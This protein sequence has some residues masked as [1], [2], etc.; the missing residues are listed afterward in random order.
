MSEKLQW[1]NKLSTA[2]ELAKDQKKL[3]LLDFY[4]PL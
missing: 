1:Q 3:I 2:V 4:S